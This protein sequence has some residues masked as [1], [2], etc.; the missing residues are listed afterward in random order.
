[1]L[2]QL[3]SKRTNMNRTI[4]RGLIFFFCI[5]SLSMAITGLEKVT[6]F[7]IS[8]VRIEGELTPAE[9][10]I[11]RKKVER[12]LEKD[13][14]PN[15]KRIVNQILELA[16]IG[17]VRVR[18]NWPD[19][20]D[21]FVERETIVARW[22]DQSYLTL[23]GKVVEIPQGIKDVLPTLRATTSDSQTAMELY[24]TVARAGAKLG[25]QV[26]EVSESALGHWT[27]RF[28]NGV[29]IELGSNDILGRL[30]RFLAVYRQVIK[31]NEQ[32]A[33]HIDA[34]YDYGIAV[35]WNISKRNLVVGTQ[36]PIGDS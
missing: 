7:E 33:L 1:M 29:E 27:A 36:R 24:R 16:W 8:T 11:L 5:C 3:I 6:K 30:G 20:M 23:E 25:L 13:P 4:K 35:E 15:P 21:V 19:A 28:T 18:R 2:S 10:L 12:V 9:K 14:S 26:W 22:G 32:A 34:R 17:T 31:G